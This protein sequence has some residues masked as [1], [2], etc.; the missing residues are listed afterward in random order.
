MY[1]LSLTA[2]QRARAK[3]AAKNPNYQQEYRARNIEKIRAISRKA[4]RKYSGLPEPT[5]PVPDHCELCGS[6][7]K[8]QALNLDHCHVT[9]GFRGWLCGTCNRALGHFGDNIEG[10]EKA[11]KYLKGAKSV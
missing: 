3:W 4:M 1:E 11:I 7:P 6:Q 5:R 10:L 2:T 8:K 9:G